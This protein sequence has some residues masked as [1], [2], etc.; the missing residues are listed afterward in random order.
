MGGDKSSVGFIYV[1]K[2]SIRPE[3]L[4]SSRNLSFAFV[5]FSRCLKVT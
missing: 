4:N 2:P 3:L 5:A 1:Y